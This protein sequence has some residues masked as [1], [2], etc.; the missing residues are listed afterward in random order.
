MD[1]LR[2]MPPY[3]AVLG[4]IIFTILLISGIKSFFKID[5]NILLNIL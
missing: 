3:Y 2:E 5:L 1:K 4:L